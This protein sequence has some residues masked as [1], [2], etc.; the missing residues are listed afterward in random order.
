MEMQELKEIWKN[1]ENKLD[2]IEQVNRK[3]LESIISKKTERKLFWM[4]LQSIFGVIGIPFIYIMVIILMAFRLE[5]N[6]I[7]VVGFIVTSIIWIYIVIK[8]ITYY[9]L[10]HKVKPKLDTIIKTKENVLKLKRFNLKWYKER[11]IYILLL[12]VSLILMISKHVDFKNTHKLLLLIAIIAGTYLW[13]IIAYK[14]YFND[15]MELIE[16]EINEIEEL[17]K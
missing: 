1:Y 17:K 10:L 6:T 13:R 15:P 3:I 7:E 4:K 2:K 5:F 16:N 12:A 14:I 8:S 9:K 11:G